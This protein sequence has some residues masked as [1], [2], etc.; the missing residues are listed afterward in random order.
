MSLK[1]VCCWPS[2]NSILTFD[3]HCSSIIYYYETK[4]GKKKTHYSFRQKKKAAGRTDHPQPSV[5]RKAEEKGAGWRW[6]RKPALPVMAS[7]AAGL[8][9]GGRGMGTVGGLAQKALSLC[10]SCV[11]DV[12]LISS[13]V[14]V[15][16]SHVSL[17][18]NSFFNSFSL[19]HSCLYSSFYN[20]TIVQKQTFFCK[21]PL[22]IIHQP[23]KFYPI[24]IDLLL[25][26]DLIGAKDQGA[27]LGKTGSKQTTL[28]EKENLIMTIMYYS[29]GIGKNL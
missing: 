19:A 6:G 5:K 18:L 8:G 15:G 9:A 3:R 25:R 20:K 26:Q 21:T 28:L 2:E 16:G 29:P 1:K 24:I 4:L 17:S 12:S 11:C 22:F 23:E 7:W 14:S 10:G 13:L 27:G